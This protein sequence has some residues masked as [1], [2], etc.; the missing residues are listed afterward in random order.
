MAQ[1]IFEY[2]MLAELFEFLPA[3]LHQES[4]WPP[5]PKQ[6]CV[7]ALTSQKQIVQFLEASCF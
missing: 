5:L 6:T 4:P 2:M 1:H 3:Y 7:S